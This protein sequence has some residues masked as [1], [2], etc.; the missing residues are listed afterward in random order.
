M[1]QEYISP[2]TNNVICEVV[3]CSAKAVEEIRVSVSQQGY[4]L[5]MV[6]SR[7]KEKFVANTAEIREAS[8]QDD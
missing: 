4:V 6:C 7:C 2:E 3:G 1:N 8:S 5:L